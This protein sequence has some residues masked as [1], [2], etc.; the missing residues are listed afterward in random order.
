MCP[1]V[2]RH[3]KQTNKLDKQSEDCGMHAENLGYPLIQGHICMKAKKSYAGR[4]R[5]T[6]KFC[7][8]NLSL[9]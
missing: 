7:S 5:V 9:N 6:D 1:A 4:R 3:P 8:L 2:G